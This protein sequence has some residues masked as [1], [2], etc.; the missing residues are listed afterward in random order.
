MFQ[1]QTG[2]IKRSY[3]SRRLYHRW[4][5]FNSKLVRL[6]AYIERERQRHD[7]ASF[8]SKLVRLKACLAARNNNRKYMFQFQTGSIKSLSSRL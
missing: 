7:N 1:F 5:R 2:S 4:Q 3:E 8:N 6:K